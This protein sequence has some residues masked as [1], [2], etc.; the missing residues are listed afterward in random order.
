MI[1]DQ[2]I[3]DGMTFFLEHLPDKLH[4]ILASRVDPELPLA[5]W[6]V[7]GELLEIRAA[8]LRFSEAEASSFFTQTL[9]EG[10]A[11]EDVQRLEQ[12]TE[13]WVAGLQLA[14]LAMR[15]RQDRSAF[16]QA[17]TGSHRYLLDY[18]QEEIL[19]HQPP[20]VQRFLLQTAVL[21]RLNASICAALTEDA[22]SQAML[23]MLERSNLYVVPLDDERQWYRVHDLFREV[24]LA[25]LQ[26]TEPELL[27]LLHQRA[28]H[29]YAAHDELREAITHALAAADFLY[30]ADLI[31]RAAERLWLSGEAQTVLDWIG[32][33]S[34]AVLRQYARL[35]LNASLRL[36]ESLHMT[37][38]EL[39]ARGQAQ[40]EQTIARV[41]AVL[42]RQ[43]EPTLPALPEA[44]VALL[45]RRIRLLRAVI[46]SRA[47]LTRGDAVRMRLL[48][49]ETEAL[50]AQEELSWKLIA[51]WISFW[52]IATLQQEEA[53]LIPRLLEAKRQV[54][55]AGDRPATLRVMR[56]LALAYT[57]AGQWR[58]V[59]QECLEALALVEQ[60]G[61]RSA[62]TG[63][64]HHSLAGAYYAWNRLD[65]AASSVQQTRRIAQVWQQTD[66]LLNGDV[67]LVQIWLARGDLAAAEQ[68]LQQA[69][70]LIQQ[71][72]YAPNTGF[73]VA[74]RVQ[75]WLAA[76]DLEAANNWAVPVVFSSEQD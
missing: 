28:A 42:Q 70:E 46:A 63:Y 7:R 52:H 25:R 44:D 64:F 15:Q 68:A 56:W 24:L 73:V 51:L 55:D 67:L 74:V 8:D 11:E 34:D 37:P 2:A 65:E 6:R 59:Q 35:A 58:L 12:R 49:Q 14:A 16:V 76:G 3:H 17:F 48:A 50:A 61:E 71:E 45:Q 5:R 30:A 4:L 57:R 75:Y 13:G 27:P 40:V 38:R 60:I 19:Q 62:M 21:R 41:E 32:A 36:L 29:W 53:L 66:L 72:Q 10:L 9:G 43:Q 39:Y 47:I 31:E 23:E 20:N 18:I 1:D 69:E 26:A 33:L 54:L 22:T